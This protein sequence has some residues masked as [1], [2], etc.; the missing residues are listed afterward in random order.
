[1]DE[2]A[3]PRFATEVRTGFRLERHKSAAESRALPSHR[4]AAA[5]PPNT[6]ISCEGGASRP[7]HGADLL[8]V[9]RSRPSATPGVLV[10]PHTWS[11]LLRD[12]STSFPPRQASSSDGGA[13]STKAYLLKAFG[14]NLLLVTI[15]ATPRSQWARKLPRL[16]RKA[17]V[18]EPTSLAA[19]CATT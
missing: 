6:W 14:P 3:S 10:K 19:Q 11:Q 15:E 13:C 16:A 1:V 18:S 5:C 17:L 8:D 9:A 12:A 2:D 4:R 7:C